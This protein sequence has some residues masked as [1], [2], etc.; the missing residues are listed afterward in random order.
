MEPVTVDTA[1]TLSREGAC[2]ACV[3]IA[4][5]LPTIKAG[6]GDEEYFITVAVD[7]KSG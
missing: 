6:V 3:K 7:P 4:V 5:R 2:P 1:A